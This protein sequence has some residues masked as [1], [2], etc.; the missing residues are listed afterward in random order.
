MA[1]EGLAAEV[2]ID[3]VHALLLARAPLILETGSEDAALFEGTVTG[4]TTEVAAI[5]GS[6]PAVGD[7]RN[8]AVWAITLGTAA[9]LE[10]ALFPEQQVGDQ[11]RAVILQR[12]YEALLARLGASSQADGE[13][14]SV[15]S[16]IG[17]FP[18]ARCYPD[19]AERPLGAVVYWP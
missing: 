1:L 17:T 3:Q 10:A 5:T 4:I 6:D 14:T 16:P 18:D 12:R 11:A 8:L 2:L 7:Y 9:Q 15:P 19:P 13:V